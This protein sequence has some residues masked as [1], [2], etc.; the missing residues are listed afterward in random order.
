VAQWQCQ[1][2]ECL[3]VPS[4]PDSKK[5]LFVLVLPPTVFDGYGSQPH[6]L[7]MPILSIKSGMVVEDACLLSVGDYPF[8]SHASFVD[9][10]FTRL[11]PVAHVK[12]CIEKQVFTVKEPCSPELLNRIIAGGLVS[13]RISREFKKMLAAAWSAPSR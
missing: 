8:I 9:Y 4:G 12:N 5:H 13:K 7:M 1:Q 6:V 2:G 11:E 3:L 10:R